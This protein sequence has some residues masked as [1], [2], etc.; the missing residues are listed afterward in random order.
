MQIPAGRP[1]QSSSRDPG[2]A[3]PVLDLG[4]LRLA[5]ERART[6]EQGIEVI[7]GLLHDFGQGGVCG[8][9]NRR[10]IYHNSFMVADPQAAWV[11][12]TAGPY[13]AAKQIRGIYAISNGLTLGDDFDRGH[14]DLGRFGKSGK[15]PHFARH[16]SNRLYTFF[17]ASRRRRSFAQGRLAGIV[18]FVVAKK[19]GYN[20][21]ADIFVDIAAMLLND[22][23][24]NR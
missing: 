18:F 7:A 8:Y 10:M 11:L 24:L 2:E 12:E 21:V 19:E 4:D 5:L 15:S 20:L 3:P 22:V 6:A 13:W 14:P 16:F 17:S 23:G 1:R 9:H